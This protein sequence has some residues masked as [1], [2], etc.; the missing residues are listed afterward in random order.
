MSP[1][2]SSKCVVN[3]VTVL[4][5]SLF[6]LTASGVSSWSVRVLD[7]KMVVLYWILPVEQC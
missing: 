1:V 2:N 6:R 5:L 7:E 3:V 4:P